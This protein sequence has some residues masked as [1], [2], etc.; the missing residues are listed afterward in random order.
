M[1]GNECRCD[2]NARLGNMTAKIKTQANDKQFNPNGSHYKFNDSPQAC[3]ALG[4][5]IKVQKTSNCY[6]L[7]HAKFN[8][9]NKM[10]KQFM[11]MAKK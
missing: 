3:S 6:G 1:G 11:Q 10:L 2:K 5:V 9:V 7:R 8:D 4:D